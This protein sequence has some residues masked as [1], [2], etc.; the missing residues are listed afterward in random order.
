[1]KNTSIESIDICVDFDGTCVTHEYPNVGKDIGAAP[2]LKRLV[3]NGHNLILFTMRGNTDLI[4]AVNWFR[5]N[6]IPLYGI[7]KNPTQL[8]WLTTSPTGHSVV[9]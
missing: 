6:E 3:Q 7:N 5:Q 2:V 4:D 8:G 9:P 1:M